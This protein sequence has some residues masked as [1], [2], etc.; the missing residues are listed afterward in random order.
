MSFIADKL[1]HRIVILKA[2]MTPNDSGGYDRSYEK[3]IEIWAQIKQNKSTFSDLVKSIR[4]TNVL[5][6]RVNFMIRTSAFK[7]F[8]KQFSSAFD[9][10][11]DT[12]ADF[13]PIDGEYFIYV[14]Y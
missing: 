14:K 4:Q 12:V 3:I 8:G 5:E 10:S 7:S 1:K 9:T 6:N 13:N 11:V 2:V